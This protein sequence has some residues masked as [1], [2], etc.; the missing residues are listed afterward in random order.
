MARTKQSQE[1]RSNAEVLKNLV[2]D[3]LQFQPEDQLQQQNTDKTNDQIFICDANG[4]ESVQSTNLIGDLL[5]T[6]YYSDPDE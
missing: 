3:Q 5:F 6:E 4:C 2:K 1:A